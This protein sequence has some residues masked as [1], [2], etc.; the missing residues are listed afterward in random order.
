MPYGF[1]MMRITTEAFGF[2]NDARVILGPPSIEDM[3]FD[4]QGHTDIVVNARRL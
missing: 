4:V 3:I 1:S 2:S